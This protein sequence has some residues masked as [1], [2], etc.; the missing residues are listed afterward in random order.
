M[1]PCM[2]ECVVFDIPCANEAVIKVRLYDMDD[3]TTDIW[4]CNPCSAE[5]GALYPDCIETL[6][7]ING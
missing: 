4:L 3:T 1:I 5:A 7:K 6:E 2:C